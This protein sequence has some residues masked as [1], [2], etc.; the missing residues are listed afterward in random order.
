VVAPALLL[1]VVAAALPA[2]RAAEG[3]VAAAPAAIGDPDEAPFPEGPQLPA[4]AERL[5][6]TI[7]YLGIAVARAMLEQLPA[8]AAGGGTLVR[9]SARTTA[10]WERF[11]HIRNTYLTRFDPFSYRPTVYVREIDQTGMRFR[12]VEWN[13]PPGRDPVAAGGL[14]DRPES[15]LP[16]A[17]PDTVAVQTVP[18]D[19]GNLFS[20]LWWMR[21]ADWART[22]EAR[23]IIWVDGTAWELVFLR[24]G[25]EAQ[26]APEGEVPAWEIRITFRRLGAEGPAGPPGPARSDYTTRELV[27]ENAVVTFWIEQAAARRPLAVKV[28]RPKVVVKGFLR[29]PFEEERIGGDR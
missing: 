17:E 6:Y 15:Y 18:A 22:K 5:T 1:L 13:G 4:Q 3:P 26:K 29:E 28:V 9:A 21:Y 10:F 11:F 24:S 7:T 14:P 8:Q 23:R 25:S 12:W 19:L 20:V 27:R 16:H 2:G